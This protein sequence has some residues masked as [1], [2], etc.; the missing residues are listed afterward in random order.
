MNSRGRSRT[1]ASLSLRTKILLAMA[2]VAAVVVGA[3]LATNFHFRR[4]QLLQ[5][6]QVFV[7][8]V[9]GTAALA[10][11]GDEISTIHQASDANSPA[12]QHAAKIL[13][14]VRRINGLAEHELYILRPVSERSPFETEF[15]VMLQRKSFIGDRYTVPPS[16]RGQFLQAWSSRLP[17]STAIYHDENG[18]WISGYAPVLDR[19]GRPVAMIEADAEIS[20]FLA[21]Q[22][23]ELLFALATGAAAFCIAMIPGLLLARSITRGL[24]KLSAGIQRFKSGDHAVQVNVTSR[25]ELEELGTV[26]NEMII[27]LGEKLA[28]LPYVSRFTAEAVRRSRDDPN[29]LAGSEREVIVLFADLRGFTNWCEAREAPLLVRELNRLLALQADVVVSA[30]GDV[31]KFIGDAVMAV[32][33]EADGSAQTVFDCARQLIERIREEASAA[34]GLGIGIHRG[35]AVVGSIGSVTRRD[36]TAIGHTVN[37]ASRLCERAGPWE[38]L[39]SESFYEMLA[40]ESRLVFERTEPMQFKNVSQFMPTY[41]CT[42]ADEAVRDLSAC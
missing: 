6:F 35:V 23:A 25:D 10:L 38:I 12:F 8:G 11:N 1:H 31:D 7:R 30:G 27:S 18:R 17:A 41:R 4:M 32:F 20:R 42:V 21:K 29:W 34:L 14:Q 36:F 9:A 24:H 39:V 16:N 33:L 3:I 15:V 2:T 28:L 19:V 13:D 26:F 40:P 37:L 22:Q 5:E